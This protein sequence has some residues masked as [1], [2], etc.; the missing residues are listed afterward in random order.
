MAIIDAKDLILGRMASS[1]AKRVL[2][3]EQIN[4]VRCEEAI[5]VGSKKFLFMHYLKRIHRG[6]PTTGPFL[7]RVPHLFVKRCIRGML[8]YHKER[9][10]RAYKR[11]LCYIG[12]PE[13]FRNEKLET[14]RGAHISK[15]QTSKYLKVGVVCERLGAD[16]RW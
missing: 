15:L 7:P 2:L 9:G 12:L 4:I 1:V 6:T 11:I 14:I 13:K 3:G 8:P 10:R 16:R 5:I